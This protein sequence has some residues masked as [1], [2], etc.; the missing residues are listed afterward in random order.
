MARY[1]V[2]EKLPENYLDK[3]SNKFYRLDGNRGNKGPVKVIKAFIEYLP[4]CNKQ[5]I[6]LLLKTEENT[7]FLVD[8]EEFQHFY[9]EI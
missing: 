7:T 3:Y 2:T 9:K 4:V 1:K 5:H 6:Q 8:E